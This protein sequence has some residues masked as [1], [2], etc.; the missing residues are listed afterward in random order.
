MSRRRLDLAG[1]RIAKWTV[2]RDAGR[3]PKGSRLWLCRCDCGTQR[4]VPASR[5]ARGGSQSCGCLRVEQPKILNRTHG[6]SKV[7]GKNNGTPTYQSWMA[8]RV[9]CAYKKHPAFHQYGGRGI[10]VC[11]RWQA[12]ENFLAD[13]GERPAGTTLDRVDNDRGYEPGNCRWA[14][15]SAQARNRRSSRRLRAHGV[16]DTIVAWS[17]RTGISA[18]CIRER[19]K[20]GWPPERAVAP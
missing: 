13:M 9:R 1:T 14:T 16:T 3:I 12:F 6:H 4:V 7:P 18:A 8:M 2:I 17:D 11:E 10:A 5:L 15:R 19:L 20:R